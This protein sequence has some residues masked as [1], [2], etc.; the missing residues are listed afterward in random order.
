MSRT[1]E[2]EDPSGY[3]YTIVPVVMAQGMLRKRGLA[4]YVNQNFRNS[5]VRLSGLKNYYINK[6]RKRTTPTDMLI[7][8]SHWVPPVDNEL[9]ATNDF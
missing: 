9:Q 5:S 8:K 6:T 1:A 2:H 3:I 4:D 7:Q